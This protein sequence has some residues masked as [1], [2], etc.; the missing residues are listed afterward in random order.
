MSLFSRFPHTVTLA[1]SVL[2]AAGVAP[3]HACSECGCSL[4]SDWAAQGYTM[5]PGF[6]TGL[7][8]EYYEQT[9]LRSGTA[10]VDRTALTFPHNSEIQQRTLNRNTWLDLNFV[11]NSSWAVTASIPYHDRFHT[12][13]AEGDTAISTSQA[14]GLGE[15][16]LLGRYQK[17]DATHSFGLQFGLKLPTGRYNQNFAGGPQ[18]GEP[19]DRGLQLGTGTTDLLVGVSW[20]AR[21]AVNLGCFIQVMLDQ[22]LAVRDGFL[23]STSLNLSGGVRWLNSSRFTPQ[24]QLNIKTE[25][26]EHGAEADTPNSGGTLVYLSPGVTVELATR[27]SAFAFVQLPVYQRVNGLQLEPIWLLSYGL[28]W[29]F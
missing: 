5:T 9:D 12:T 8:F 11:V 20:F 7:R 23:P 24:L 21:P 14:S 22:P 26:R 25:S 3:A 2:T 19:L 13:I 27:A 1:V 15:V 18:A 28:R 17:Y 16:R 6:E 29:K 10:S 4:S